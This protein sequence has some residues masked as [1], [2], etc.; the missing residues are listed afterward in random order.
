MKL[1]RNLLAGLANSVWTAL[2]SLAVIPLY[3]KFLGIEAYGLIGF[4]ATTQALLQILDLG[5]AP[6]INREVA[7]C[8]AVGNLREAGK[9]LHTLA[10][11]YW[12]M[13]GAIA[14]ILFAL[15]PFVAE[16]WLKSKHIPRETVAHGVALM[17]LVVACRWPIGLYQGA[18][19]GAQ[20]LAVS[21]GIN[22]VM[23]TIGNFGAVGVLAFVSPTIQAFFVWQAGVGLVYAATIRWAAWRV[24]GRTGEVQFDGNQLKR[25][26]HFSMGM[27]GIAL[28]SLV[29][30]QLDKVLLSKILG[31]EEFGRYMLATVVVSALYV[32]VTPT[33]NT[34]Y[35]R[36]SALV[37]SGNTE[38]L[39]ESYRLGTRLLAT[40]IFPITMTLVIFAED[41]VRMWTGNPDIASSV[42]PVIGVL[43]IGSSLNGVMHFPYAL[44]LAHGMPRLPL[45]INAILMVVMVPLIVFLATSYGALGGAIAWFVL[46]IFYVMIGTWVTHRHLLI[47]LGNKWLFQ[48]VGIPLGMSSLVGLVGTYAIHGAGYPAHIKLAYGVVLALVALLL[49]LAVSPQLRTAM[50]NSF[51]SDRRVSESWRR[52][53]R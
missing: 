22:I 2:V 12:G 23:V 6:T 3:L 53:T 21:S 48:D 18:L 38:K 34:I 4:F 5:L 45:S 37:A 27:S 25:V 30:T 9:L 50:W 47:G 19:M 14:L 13:A 39:A 52:P 7:R 11:V 46:H 51:G 1:G 8:S 32:L 41:L 26:L 29:F 49:T 15:A 43:A 35:P 16:Y 28:S 31:L 40:V 42:A 36:F 33:F 20:R 24:V 10:F 44:Q 17:G